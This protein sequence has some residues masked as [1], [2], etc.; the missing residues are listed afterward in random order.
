MPR[1]GDST[2]WRQQGLAKWRGERERRCL[3]AGGAHQ[4]MSP[5]LRKS[6]SYEQDWNT[7]NT[8]L[9]RYYGPILI[10]TLSM[11]R[12]ILRYG[13]GSISSESVKRWKRW[14]AWLTNSVPTALFGH[15][16]WWE[17]A[18]DARYCIETIRL[19]VFRQYECWKSK[20]ANV[21]H[22]NNSL[23]FEPI[24]MWL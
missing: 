18:I 3:H 13:G 24:S 7:L 12:S 1:K 22:C 14:Y 9:D 6:S 19:Y 8:Q 16:C 21:R 4:R 17:V 10:H 11:L 5:H 2:K 20:E 23:N 15:F